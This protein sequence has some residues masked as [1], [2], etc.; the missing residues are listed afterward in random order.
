MMQSTR[1]PATPGHLTPVPGTGQMEALAQALILS[2][3][4]PWGFASNLGQKISRKCLGL[5]AR[6]QE[7]L[8]SV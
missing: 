4:A 8:V 1:P 7:F 6:S 3:L 2:S 5:E